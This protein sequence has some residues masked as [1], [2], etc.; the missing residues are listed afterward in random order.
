MQA[1]MLAEA[2]AKKQ[3]PH[4]SHIGQQW[5]TTSILK[6]VGSMHSNSNVYNKTAADLT[7]PATDHHDSLLLYNQG[8]IQGVRGV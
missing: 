5:S 4:T 2:C 6:A 7:F 8:T 1:C 3:M